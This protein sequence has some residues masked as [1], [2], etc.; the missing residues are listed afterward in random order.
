[1]VGGFAAGVF[2][3]C[4][5]ALVGIMGIIYDLSVAQDFKGS[6]Q[7]P[8]CKASNGARNQ[9][10]LAGFKNRAADLGI[11]DQPQGDGQKLIGP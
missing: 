4:V 11:A 7:R 5:P 8:V 3:S 1:M 10:R 6:L 2:I 9:K